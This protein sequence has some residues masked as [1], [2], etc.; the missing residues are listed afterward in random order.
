MFKANTIALSICTAFALAGCASLGELPDKLSQSLRPTENRQADMSARQLYQLAKEHQAQQRYA[1]AITA[2]LEA[3]KRD[4]LLADA[5]NGLG[6][7]YSEQGRYEEAVNAFKAAIDLKPQAGYLYSNLGYALLLEDLNQEALSPLETAVALEPDNEK[8][9]FNLQFAR[10][11]LGMALLMPPEKS[12]E[13]PQPSNLAETAEPRDPNTGSL[14]LVAVAPNMYE[15]KAREEITPLQPPAAE[16]PLLKSEPVRQVRPFRVEVSNGNGTKGMARQVAGILD[17]NGIH[18][19][20][21][22]NHGTF[23]Q[24]TTQ[25]QYRQGYQAEAVALRGVFPAQIHAVPGSALREDIQVRVLLGKDATNIARLSR[26]TYALAD[27]AHASP[28]APGK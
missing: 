7:I 3:L 13:K 24:T 4:P 18:A 6:I 15:L 5:H 9:A 25:I 8:A 23:R 16:Q 19:T 12:T 27:T 22:T 14:R 21:I 20:R 26:E 28:V 1:L 2:Y 11:R 17:H 10:V